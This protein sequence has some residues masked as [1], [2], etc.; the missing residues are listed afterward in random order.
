[1]DKFFSGNEIYGDNFDQ[2]QIDAWFADEQEGYANLG[3]AE[4]GTESDY[5]YHALNRRLGFRYLPAGTIDSAL[6]LGSAYGLEFLPIADRLQSITILEPSSQLR[7]TQLRNVPLNYVDPLPSGDIPFA[8]DSF[9]LVL[10]L[11]VLHHI[12]NVS[13][14]VS[15]IGRIL[16]PRGHALIREPVTSMG[17]WRKARLGLTA[18][19]RGIPRALLEDAIKSASMD[20][21]QATPCMFPT[22]RRLARYGWGFGSA[23]GVRVDA[24]LSALTKWNNRYHATAKWHKLRPNSVFYVTE[25]TSA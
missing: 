18:R 7:G 23:R 5:G 24:A 3:A 15:E 2:A 1:M 4:H 17:D 11:G 6:G 9:Q 16:A 20:I 8:D 22:T 19:E 13:H 25:K 21:V 10:S 12:P 14:V